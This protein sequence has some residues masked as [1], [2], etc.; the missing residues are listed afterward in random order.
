MGFNRYKN[1]PK[2][3]SFLKDFEK[4]MDK[5]PY[6]LCTPVSY[7]NAIYLKDMLLRYVDIDRITNSDIDE[8]VEII[9]QN[10]RNRHVELVIVAKIIFE[11]RESNRY[12]HQ[13]TQQKAVNTHLFK[14]R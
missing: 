14:I 10:T 13:I 7:P 4:A 3:V 5:L 1:N 6:N 11:L 12:D 2:F 9:R 8:I